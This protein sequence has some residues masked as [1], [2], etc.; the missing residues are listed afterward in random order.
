[1][2]LVNDK[3]LK[4][5]LSQDELFAIF[6][7]YSPYP[8]T[9]KLINIFESIQN[10]YQQK[11]YSKFKEC[12]FHYLTICEYPDS[13]QIVESLQFDEFKTIIS[14]HDFTSFRYICEGN[15]HL[16]S[17]GGLLSSLEYAVR[18]VLLDIER[19]N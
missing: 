18:L 14:K 15:D 13:L 6:E 12:F 1:M 7:N 16:E 9:H 3:L 10:K 17:H 2:E 11:M 8:E 19:A 4:N 5:R